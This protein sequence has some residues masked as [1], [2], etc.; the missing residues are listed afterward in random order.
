MS[1]KE[2]KKDLQNKLT[3]LYTQ[4]QFITNQLLLMAEKRFVTSFI[5][6]IPTQ[7]DPL[8]SVEIQKED[9]DSLPVNDR[10]YVRLTI[11]K[12][13][14]PWKFGDTHYM[15]LNEYEK[16]KNNGWSRETE[17]TDEKTS[18]RV[19]PVEEDFSDLPF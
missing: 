13:K 17:I 8:L 11:F 7:Y 18:K 10:W 16:W 12:K 3:T 4:Y 14:E 9:F 15:I 19:Q 1:N 6:E 5:K 2:Q